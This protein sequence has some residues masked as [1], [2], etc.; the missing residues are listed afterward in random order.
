M[1]APFVGKGRQVAIILYARALVVSYSIQVCEN[2]SMD[3]TW[4]IFLFAGLYAI[5]GISYGIAASVVAMVLISIGLGVYKC[6]TIRR[7]KI[8]RS[9]TAQILPETL[10]LTEF[11]SDSNSSTHDQ[12]ESMNECW[13]LLYIIQ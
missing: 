13:Y 11:E 12:S 1:L 7:Q 5:T 9:S 10:P 4:L 6:I 3:N 2:L 8:Y